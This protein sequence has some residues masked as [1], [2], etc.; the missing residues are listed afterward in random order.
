MEL[1]YEEQLRQRLS[2]LPLDAPGRVG[3]YGTGEHTELLLKWYPRLLGEIKADVFVIQSAKENFR[4]TK[5]WNESF[6]VEEIG[7][8]E[9][10]SVI[11]S[12]SFYEEELAAEIQRLYGNR[13]SLYRF[14]DAGGDNIFRHVNLINAG[15]ED[16]PVLRIRFADMSGSFN[17]YRNIVSNILAEHYRLDYSDEPELLIYNHF[18]SSHLNYGNCAKL[19]WISEV[20]ERYERS[21]YDYAFGF[22]Y[23][24]DSGFLH[25]NTYIPRSL[26]GMERVPVLRAENR[27]FC[28]FI[29]SNDNDG[30]GTALRKAFCSR[31]S[32][33]YRKVD[34][35]GKVLNNMTAQL[36][37]R[38]DRDWKTSKQQFIAGYKFTIAFENNQRPGYSTEKIWDAFIAGSV[39]V[40]WGDTEICGKTGVNPDAFINCNEFGNDI[41]A[42]VERVK[43]I[44]RDDEAYLRMLHAA[45]FPGKKYS[46]AGLEAFLVR[47][48]EECRRK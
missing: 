1:N 45:P 14:Y 20:R 38:F 3:I 40:Y 13:F 37:G 25:H 23:M 22:P 30:D 39:P 44:D 43:E 9:L 21:E 12:S 36:Q 32:E 4:D 41:S 7:G 29:Y 6:G 31:L 33:S 34:C 18:G 46:Q 27:K 24:D 35:P 5:F 42:M 15:K 16:R 26:Y 47:I 17:I 19:F 28:N 48:A 8:L 2:V 11:L 10:D